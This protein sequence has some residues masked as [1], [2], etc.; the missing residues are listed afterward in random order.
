MVQPESYI[1]ANELFQR[2]LDILR[3]PDNK[4][5]HVNK[6]LHETL[7]LT[8][9]AGLR[10]SPYGFGDLNARVDHLCT[11]RG[12]DATDVRAIHKMR[13]DS[14]SSALILPE[15]VLFDVRA[16][17]IFISAVFS[18]AIPSILVGK[19]PVH[20]QPMNKNLRLDERYIRCTVKKWDD[21]HIWVNTEQE[22]DGELLKVEY[23]SKQ[24][25]F[26]MSYLKDILRENMQLNL[27]D[28]QMDGHLVTPRI[29]IVEPDYLIDISSL[30]ACFTD[31]G[32]HPALFT[33]NRMKDKP[34]T[35]HT[36]LGNF[37]GSALDH[38]VHTRQPKDGSLQKIMQDNYRE[39]ALEYSTCADFDPTAF[40][41]EAVRQIQN[42]QQMIDELFNTYD[43]EKAI[44]E[45]SFVCEK[46]GLQ[47]R[48]DLMTTDFRLLVEQKSGKNINIEYNQPNEHGNQHIEAHYVQALLYGAVLRHNFQ[49][50]A[51]ATKIFLLYSKYPLPSGLLD[52]SRLDMLTHEA[53]KLRNLIVSSDF[54]T[55]IQGAK[56]ILEELIPSVLNTKGIDNYFY[57]QFL[58]PQ[59]MQMTSPIEQMTDLEKAYVLRMMKFVM[60][61][62]I[63]S[64]TGSSDGN[65]NSNADLWNMPLMEKKEMGNIFMGLK[66]IKKES[67]QQRGYDQITLSIP[68]QGEDFLPNFRRGDMVYLY[69]YHPNS[70]PDVR[71]SI[72]FKGFIQDIKTK[73][74]M[75]HLADAQ[76]NEEVLYMESS[77]S[78]T[79]DHNYIV[80]AI[81]HSASDIGG[82]GAIH[83]L[84]TLITAPQRRKDLLLGQRNPQS[85]IE[86]KLSRN[87]HPH[88]DEIL[89]KAKQAKDYFLIVGPPGTGKTSMALRF[90]VEEELTELNSSVLLMAYT[91]R[92]VDEICSMLCKARIPFIRLGN[93]YSCDPQFKPYL[94][95]QAI[96]DNLKLVYL[97]NRLQQ[98]RVIVSTTSSM[99]S[100]PFIFA[101]KHFSLAIIDEAS[102]I[103][104]PNIIGILASH[105]QTRY[106]EVT[107]HAD[108]NIDK[109]IL[110][111]DYKQ[112]PAVVQQ[113]EADARITE[114]LL[115]E[116]GLVDCRNSLFERLFHW[117]HMQHRT[118][119]IGTLRVQG[120]MHPEIAAFPNR[121]F[122]F[123]EQLIPVPLKHQSDNNVG[124]LQPAIDELDRQ[125]I[126]NR[127]IYYPSK[128]CKKTNIS[129]KVNSDEAQKVADLLQRIY[130]LSGENFDTQQTIGVIVPY[131]NQIAM[132]RKEIEKLSM[133][134]LEDI[135]IDTVERY[136]GSQRDVIIYSLTIQNLYQLDFL[137]AN[138]FVEDGH[139]IDRKLNVAITRARKQLI[140]LGNEEILSANSL[141]K[142]LIENMPCRII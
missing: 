46:L 34:N 141:F 66:I 121:M 90:L 38:L 129:D 12:I 33:L 56:N 6:M 50:S 74:I 105:L 30:A 15:Q 53:L 13:R 127:L 72:L 102:Q 32:H 124:Y 128:F 123:K 25:F 21:Q 104:E 4:K 31:Y 117:E 63:I 68:E 75:I 88:Y 9:A 19:I 101:V 2:T 73:E 62:Q 77:E 107:T 80:Y 118:Q 89:L 108:V 51:Q 93:E 71:R 81:E 45:P 135:C 120:R 138:S 16:L 91:N 11:Q 42:I 59:L 3:V 79:Q 125:L 41:T 139:L 113:N 57:R 65:G 17:A 92:A 55:G 137:T 69:G 130:R 60:K 27:L 95:G 18:E 106:G 61:E 14:N 24:Q 99:I 76:Q 87:Y 114:P 132:I 134:I 122:Y 47:G 67:T 96:E 142:K 37:A 22:S 133:P 112:L 5:G 20:G 126:Q 103:L 100:R 28:S 64:K 29:I 110:I 7:V 94:M 85:I 48:V 84:Y 109:F 10:N 111:G 39:K 83:A 86:K 115:H 54:D 58:L 78:K 49:L 36:L 1:T 140:L 44:L 98:T 82:N 35:H 43:R 52:V 131:R 136:Q 70:E 97:R 119:F 116:I 8:C 23:S 40:K 26:D